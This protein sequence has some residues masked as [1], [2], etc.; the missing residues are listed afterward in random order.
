MKQ[1]V[2]MAMAAGLVL[3]SAMAQ[4]EVKKDS[5]GKS[6]DG[7][8]LFLYTLHD[9]QLTVKLTNFGAHVVSIDAPDKNGNVA[10]VVLGFK[11]VAG[12]ENPKN[13]SYMGAIV[14]RYGNRI[15]NGRFSLDGKSYE[16]PTNNNGNALHGGK[17]GFDQKVWQG[18]EL[19]N[20]VEFTLVSPDGDM[21]FPGKLT[22]HVKYTLV[23]S[24]LHID[25]TA[26]TDKDT[27]VNLTNHS[28]F[29]LAGEEVEQCSMNR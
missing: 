27:V 4:G 6:A 13:T 14:G 10:D 28:Y 7:Q 18:K 17:V 16:I 9:A 12:Y 29:N 20:G 11:D 21:G 15:A 3:T 5:W 19:P 8:P 26:T 1:A 22:A 23:G 24:S 2:S 25:Y